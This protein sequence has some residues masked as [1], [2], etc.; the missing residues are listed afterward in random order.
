MSTVFNCIQFLRDLARADKR[1]RKQ[2]LRCITSEQMEAVSEVTR[3]LLR[4]SIH[5]LRQDMVH[6]RER[7][8]LLR[9]LADGRIS[10]RRKRTAL[11]TYHEI[12]PR[13]L[14]HHYL[15]RAIVLSMQTGEQ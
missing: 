11:T 9:Q 15:Q 7:S 12:V 3:F 1:T 2:L 8:L 6:F 10:L 13:L 14:R 4:G 5:I